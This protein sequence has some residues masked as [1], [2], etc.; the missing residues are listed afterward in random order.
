ME[1]TNKNLSVVPY[2]SGRFPHDD[3]QFISASG[4]NWAMALLVA[5]KRWPMYQQVLSLFRLAM[6]RILLGVKN[7]QR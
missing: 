1:C 6:Q 2:V 3:N 7:S 4:T 5:V